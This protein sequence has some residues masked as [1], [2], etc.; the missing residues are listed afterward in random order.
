MNKVLTKNKVHVI[1]SF[2]ECIPTFGLN[3]LPLPVNR[4][5]FFT[6]KI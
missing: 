2:S 6:S 4:T 5:D 1:R 3:M